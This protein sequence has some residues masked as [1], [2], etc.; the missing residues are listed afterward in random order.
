MAGLPDTWLRRLRK[1]APASRDAVYQIDRRLRSIE[2]SL[3]LLRAVALDGRVAPLA[4]SADATAPDPAAPSPRQV[5]YGAFVNLTE[6]LGN[7]IKALVSARDFTSRIYLGDNVLNRVFEDQYPVVDELPEGCVVFSDWRLPPGS[8]DFLCSVNSPFITLAEPQAGYIDLEYFRIP[9]DIRVRIA[10][11][12][13]SLRPAAVVREAVERFTADWRGDV[14]AV[15]VRSWTD[16][17]Q[18]RGA[19]F[20][21][22][23]VFRE[24][25][26]RNSAFRLFLSTDSVAVGR[27]FRERYGDRLLM[28]PFGEPSSD[29][30]LLG[31]GEDETALRALCDMLCLARGEILIG[32][33]LSTFTE[34]AWWFGGARQ[35]VVIL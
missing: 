10:A 31:L 34:C 15:H 28:N 4:A 20:D 32:T 17:P 7:R 9:P 24:I 22:D 13:A 16:A 27:A 19:L 29:G 21:Q 11:I 3:A 2:Q 14:I 25:D 26:R 5:R 30:Q 33:F 35:S 18:R 1:V 6:G 23:G 8:S 12:F